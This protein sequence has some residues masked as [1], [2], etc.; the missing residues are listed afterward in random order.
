M[1]LQFK[2]P[3]EVKRLRTRKNLRSL[4]WP[5]SMAFKIQAYRSHG[6]VLFEEVPH[7]HL[8]T[9]FSEIMK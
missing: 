9:S 1:W 4:T 6:I 7:H 2:I 5:R 8:V 3:L